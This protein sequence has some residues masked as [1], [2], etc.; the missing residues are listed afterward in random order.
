MDTDRQ[1]D[2]Q[3]RTWGGDSVYKPRRKATEGTGP[4][5]A[6]VWDLHPPGLWSLVV[7][8]PADSHGCPSPPAP[9][10]PG[11]SSQCEGRLAGVLTQ[12]LRAGEP[13]Y[14]DQATP[15]LWRCGQGPCP[16]HPELLWRPCLVSALA[17]VLAG[18]S[19]PSGAQHRLQ[20]W[21]NAGCLHTRASDPLPGSPTLLARGLQGSRP[22][23][24]GAR[25]RDGSPAQPP[26]PGHPPPPRR[27][28]AVP[29][30]PGLCP[31]R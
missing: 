30:A 23:T 9:G 2:N 5:L 28:S 22:L 16:G 3:V 25:N 24:D 27:R 20:V 10:R 12:S 18:A 15:T 4:A 6:W 11:S 21:S 8:A 13:V 14:R 31:R 26:P 19:Q 29:R 1:R 7:A 17:S